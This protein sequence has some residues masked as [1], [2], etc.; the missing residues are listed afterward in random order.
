MAIQN[1][2]RSIDLN[3]SEKVWRVM[4]FLQFMALM[5]YQKIFFNRVDKF[6]DGYE[7]TYPSTMTENII[8]IN[9]PNADEEVEINQELINEYGEEIKDVELEKFEQ[10]EYR[11]RA[12]KEKKR[13]F[14]NCWYV[15]NVES[16]SLWNR[17][18]KDNGIAIQS[19][20][21]KL[22]RSLDEEKKTIYMFKIKYIEFERETIDSDDSALSFCPFIYKR[23]ELEHE[24][25]LRLLILANQ[26]KK[27]ESGKSGLNI[28]VNLQELIEK[29][30]VAPGTEFWGMDLVNAILKRYNLH[31][32]VVKSSM[33][34]K[35]Y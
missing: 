10:V 33:D 20:I 12:G 35:P 3:D 28:A 24:R 25:E 29:I 6:S 15:N 17:Y 2:Q 11:E 16:E 31:K 27:G 13:T 18:S 9:L 5:E 22:K 32:P 26:L 14:A 21:G 1:H 4:N 34:N 7:G 19:T 23:K 8:N 30:T